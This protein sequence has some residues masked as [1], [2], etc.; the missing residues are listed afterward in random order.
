MASRFLGRCAST[1]CR[2]SCRP[3]A[4]SARLSPPGAY[5]AAVQRAQ[6]WQWV[7]ERLMC[8]GRTVIDPE[9]FPLS[10]QR[11][12]LDE[13]IENAVEPESILA[14]WAAHGGDGHQAGN[15]LRYWT[16][17]MI[18]TSG[19]FT[20][21]PS[22]VM[23][24]PRLLNMMDRLNKETRL[25]WNST[26]VSVLRALWA[27]QLPKSDPVLRSVQTEVMWRTRR[28]S[29]KHLGLLVEWG[30]NRDAPMDV[31]VVNTA[32][33]QL[34][35]RWTEISE[36]KTVSTLISNRRRLSPI[37]YSRLEDK[38]LELAESFSAEDIGKV[39][40]SMAAQN[41]RSVPLLRALSYYL[42]QKSS[43]E[44]T[45]PLILDIAFAYGKLNFNNPELFQRLVSE[46]LPRIPEMSPFDVIRCTKS[47]SLLKWLH[48]PLFEAFAK[49]YT[50][51]SENY[52]TL[53]LCN[54]LMSFARLNFQPSN[55]EEFYTKVH[56]ALE[57]SLSDLEPAFETDAVWSLCVL[58]QAKPRYL[59]PLMQQSHITKLSEGS[60]AGADLY[61]LKLIQIAASFHL[62]HPDFSLS[63][64]SLSG[65][66]VS[67][68]VPPLTVLQK[69]L[70]EALKNFVGDRTDALRTGVDTVYGWTIEG[71]LVLDCDNKPVDLSQLKAPHLPSGGGEQALPAGAQR[72]AVLAWEFAHFGSKSRD[73][74]GR[75]AMMKRHL[76]LA[77]FIVVEVPYYEWQGLKTDWQRLEYLKGKM[78]K[79]L[80]EDM[81]K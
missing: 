45:T 26:L 72:L 34:E 44:L 4:A 59:T 14:A 5:S 56:S 71:E 81:A 17:L 70:R 62:E 12:K 63:L 76:I 47:F 2:A 60:T 52:D 69:T 36:A 49:N 80:A 43:S 18:M 40:V 19:K 64:P 33:K 16:R 57:D 29:C 50:E 77:D 65:L 51:N 68:K 61:R 24:D 73:L 3:A 20:D 7:T 58:Q 23:T 31:A 21:E 41:H 54:L 9:T 66:S 22:E 30:A 53:R 15:A 79:A 42:Q 35:L 25:V 74:L 28:L 13:L 38:V 6:G 55:E 39:C 11:S 37:L 78:G 27:M 8:E 10:P 67:A 46:L 75:F 48:I 1:L 32:L